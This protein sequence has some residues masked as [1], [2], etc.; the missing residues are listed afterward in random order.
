[1]NPNDLIAIF[2]DWTAAARRDDIV[3]F[4]QVT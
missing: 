1:M 2:N 4:D 3:I